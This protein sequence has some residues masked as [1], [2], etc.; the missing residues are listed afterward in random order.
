MLTVRTPVRS[1]P[2]THEAT[3]A[4]SAVCTCTSSVAGSAMSGALSPPARSTALRAPSAIIAQATSGC[5]F[6]APN[7][8]NDLD[9]HPLRADQERIGLPGGLPV[10]GDQPHRHPEGQ[11]DEGVDAALA[12]PDPVQLHV[13]HHRGVVRMR[14][15]RTLPGDRPVVAHHQHDAGAGVQPLHHVQRLVPPGHV[16]SPPVQR[17]RVQVVH[18]PVR[19]VAD[20]RGRPR[21]QRPVNRRV[22]LAEQQPPPLLVRHPGR[23][24]LRPVDDPGHALH[25]KRNKDLHKNQNLY[26]TGSGAPPR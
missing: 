3:S 15:H 17:R 10:P 26:R 18:R 5:R 22:D 12:H 2:R 21:R 11:R 20:D 6:S 14:E 4:M 23:P 19:V 25:I 9:H 8:V 24:A 16:A 7:R 1:T 13:R